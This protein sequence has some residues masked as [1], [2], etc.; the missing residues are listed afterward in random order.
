VEVVSST[1]VRAVDA[2]RA[3]EDAHAP[4]NS[5]SCVRSFTPAPRS[6]CE[7]DRLDR[8][9]RARSPRVVLLALAAALWACDGG[10]G[11]GG[12]GG[13]AG[14]GSDAGGGGGDG[15]VTADAGTT[16][17]TL[18]LPVAPTFP[19][20][21]RVREAYTNTTAEVSA[22]GRVTVQVGAT[23]VA[24]I[25]REDHQ[26]TRFSWDNATTY[27][28]M[29]DRFQNGNP[30]NDE[31][32]G[33]RRDG[34]NE[35]GTWHGGDL[36][37]LTSKLD[38]LEAL[39][40]DSLWITS[41]VEQVH[42]WVGGGAGDFQH[43]GYH[44]YWALDFTKL[45]ANLGTPAEFRAFVDAAHAKGIRV[46]LDVVMNHPGYA[47][48]ADLA[49]YL[50]EVID[51]AGYRAYQRDPMDGFHSWNRLV[52]YNSM[53]WR[54]WWGPQWIRAGFPGHDPAGM[55]ELRRS[56]SFL[57]DFRTE[58]FR[59][60]PL[61]PILTRK[62]DTRAVPLANAPVREY[63]AQWHAD[64]VREYGVDGFRCDT[65]K[66][67]DFESWRLLK[68]R[69]AAALDAWKAANPSKRL[70]D[71]DFWMT[72]E[73]FPHGV[74]RDAYF[75]NG[76]DSLIN[77]DFQRDAARLIGDLD[78]LDATYTT[79]ARALNTDPTFNVLSYIS[80]HD[81]SLFYELNG[82]S[83]AKQIQVGTAML[84]LPGGVQIFYG[85][86]SG[87]AAGPTASDEIQ[88]T[89]SDMNWSTTDPAI[90]AH[91]QALGRFRR[92][93]LAIGAG[94]HE[95]LAADGAYAFARTYDANGVKDAVVVA[96]AR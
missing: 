11:G 33:R 73:V 7:N 45:D 27:F 18:T 85:D 14:G 87:R 19:A 77:F 86:E 94:T 13:D 12:G 36:A 20:G 24:L 88:G 6:A 63:L 3:D 89:R 95:R 5:A 46:L 9:L 91:W 70:D 69:S 2:A 96:I 38:Y 25:E 80:S 57:P 66:H 30:A 22:D 79:Y 40:V 16:G 55:D 60:V 52:N 72:G 82:K 64:W 41:P 34:A 84:L 32:Y 90:L 71:E 83:A 81:T 4:M 75:D 31:S 78:A 23:G 8:A 49:E 58:D 37:G 92:R 50:P 39:G 17:R 28:V 54:N 53:A 1:Y 48:G 51:V 62:A 29:I 74:V 93:H 65:A 44:G 43:Y 10:T 76:F 47:T 56:L 15:S 42:G 67:V 26:P 35:V 59:A 68:T 61:A 21:T